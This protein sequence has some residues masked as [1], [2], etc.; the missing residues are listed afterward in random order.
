M[1]YVSGKILTE[2]GFKKGYLCL[3]EGSVTDQKKG[4]PPANPIMNG[5]IVPTFIDMH[6]HI[7]DSFIRK[8]Q[9]SLPKDILKLVAPPDG[10]KHRLL[11]ETSETEIIQGMI[12]TVQQ[13]ITTGTTGFVDFRE[14]GLNGIR[15]IKK[16]L[17]SE[18]IQGIVLGRP[19]EMIVDKNEIQ[20]ILQDADGIG[21]SSIT[22][23]DI[24][25]LYDIASLTHKKGKLFALHASERI[26]EDINTIVELQ[27]TFIIHMT[28]A[29]R[30]DLDYIKKQ[31]IPIVI[32]PR[33]NS[34]FG[35]DLPSSL[36]K[37]VG[38]TI[39]IGSDNAMLHDPSPLLEIKHLLQWYP[40]FLTLEQLLLT[41][42]YAP[43]KV[44]N[45]KDG[46]P[47]LTFPDSFLVLNQQT[48]E[49][50]YRF[51]SGKSG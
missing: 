25:G 41:I 44:L 31:G 36:L 4:M 24:D 40:D 5:L 17:T 27:P 30:K 38:N 29:S 47:H 19:A 33:S 51:L 50:K 32:C 28:K 11:K 42:T 10:L 48:L 14:N 39:L 34:F 7:G 26:R 2:T 3:K 22:D 20:S 49:P 9:L 8:K 35:G 43:R 46:I 1:K 37:E 18:P 16:V 6:T 13:M 23:W 15:L 12:R 21:I 45:L